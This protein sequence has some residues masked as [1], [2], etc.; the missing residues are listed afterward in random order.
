MIEIYSVTNT[1]RFAYNN[2]ARRNGSSLEAGFS[3]MIAETGP[4]ASDGGRVYAVSEEM[5]RES[6][7]ASGM[8][9]ATYTFT[10]K[11]STFGVFAGRNVNYEV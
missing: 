10:G 6:L 9:V 1:G 11:P 4:S 5:L 3:E 7:A 8:E 2:D